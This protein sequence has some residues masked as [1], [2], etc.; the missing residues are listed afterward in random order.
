[1]S[2][3]RVLRTAVEVLPSAPVAA[4]AHCWVVGTGVEV[5]PVAHGAVFAHYTLGRVVRT[6]VEV[7]LDAHGAVFAHYTL[8]RVVVLPVSRDAARARSTLFGT[9]YHV[10]LTVMGIALCATIPFV[11]QVGAIEVVVVAIELAAGSP[12]CFLGRHF[13]P[14]TSPSRQSSMVSNFL[15]L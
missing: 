2:L 9:P 5:L 11:V 3:G 10:L 14:P 8:G 12:T 15:L 6:G 7:L 1:M 4:F 13:S